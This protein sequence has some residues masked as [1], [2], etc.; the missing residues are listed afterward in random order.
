MLYKQQAS[1]RM[2]HILHAYNESK[3]T[4][5]NWQFIDMRVSNFSDTFLEQP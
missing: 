2:I 5:K 3:R 4:N 1:T